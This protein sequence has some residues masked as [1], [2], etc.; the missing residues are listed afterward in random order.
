MLEHKLIK[1]QG[2]R[3]HQLTQQM[4]D[5]HKR[6]L[7]MPK[8]RK[9]KYIKY[10]NYILLY[11]GKEKEEREKAGVGLLLDDK[12]DQSTIKINYINERVTL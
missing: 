11:G 4:K 12:Y 2:S 1:Q 7:R 8:G 5:E 10:E 6:T 3:D 9:R